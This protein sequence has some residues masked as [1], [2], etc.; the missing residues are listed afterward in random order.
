MVSSLDLFFGYAVHILPIASAALWLITL[1]V[2]S[3]HTYSRLC[4]YLFIGTL[5]AIVSSITLKQICTYICDACDSTICARPNGYDN[6]GMP[7]GHTQLAVFFA[8]FIALVYP[9]LAT[10][11]AAILFSVYMGYTR[12]IVF[13]MHTTSQVIAGAVVGIAQ[14]YA[15]YLVYSRK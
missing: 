10:V 11:T 2:P 15:T 5:I 7:S 8:V 13:N 9:N 12:V 14:A 3:F 6:Y 4:L 1:L